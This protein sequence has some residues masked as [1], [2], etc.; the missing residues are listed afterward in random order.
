MRAD[1]RTRRSFLK[2][3][4]IAAVGA[5]AIPL[6][7]ACSQPA[8]PAATSAPAKT[9]ESKPAAQPT[10]A[11]AKPAESKPAESK[12]VAAA[13]AKTSGTGGTLQ[14]WVELTFTNAHK[15]SED[16][17]KEWGRANGY[18]V[19]TTVIEDGDLPQKISAAIEANTLPDIADFDQLMLQR[20]TAI[21]K[22]VDVSDVYD[23][24]GAAQGGWMKGVQRLMDPKQF[25]P[26]KGYWAIPYRSGGNVLNWRQDLLD[27]AGVAAPKTW[28]ELAD[29][30]EKAQ[31]P[32]EYWGMG[33]SLAQERDA[34]VQITVMQTFGARVADDAGK[35]V[36][37]N[38]PEALEYLKWI[39]DAY[40]RRK[41][42]PPGVLTWDGTGDNNSYQSGQSIFILNPGSVYRWM[43]KNDQEMLE[44]TRYGAMPGGP[45]MRLSP[46]SASVRGVMATSKQVEAAK[47]LLEHL[48]NPAVMSKY[49]A[50]SNH[51][52][53]LE[54]Q[55][56]MDAFKD[57]FLAGLV[58]LAEN[59]TPTGYPDVVNTAWNE[60][61]NQFVIPKMIQR[62]VVD[63]WEPQRALD[64]AHQVTSEI[65]AKQG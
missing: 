10:T 44:G 38:S 53:V 49:Y 51:G 8:P 42:F 5:T 60:F 21:D 33:F 62:V 17:A 9:G 28:H 16:A 32:G 46:F 45:K 37:L 35:K 27:K 48:M 54:G 14:Y 64:E 15:A 11:A 41:L 40:L 63:N 13:P 47:S 1:R 23:R 55:K 59:G 43:Q 26:G 56:S 52:P 2:S 30:A 57:P 65:Y 58:D 22:L 19:V 61:N 29:V 20:L 39:S 18:E 36:T 4:G 25:K 7:Q 24:I 34:N 31:K 6:L 12:P 50:A 3:L